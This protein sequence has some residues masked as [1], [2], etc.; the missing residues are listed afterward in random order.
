MQ[1]LLRIAIPL[2][3]LAAGF[4]AWQ[5]LGQSPEPP[6]PRLRPP[7]RVRTEVLELQPTRFPVVLRSQGTVRA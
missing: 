4:G 3:V 5:W 2:A 7:Q 1:V 6:A